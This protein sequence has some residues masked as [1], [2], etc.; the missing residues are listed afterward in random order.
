MLD[1]KFNCG[2]SMAMANLGTCNV[3]RVTLNIQGT[4]QT[5]QFSEAE[6]LIWLGPQVRAK[7]DVRIPIQRTL[8]GG[9]ASPSSILVKTRMLWRIAH[10]LG[11]AVSFG[12]GQVEKYT[13]ELSLAVM[14][15]ICKGGM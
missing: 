15:R 13:E 14:P 4:E 12:S 5:T 6:V 9:D 2:L 8:M 10:L 3:I 1:V 11:I 7:P